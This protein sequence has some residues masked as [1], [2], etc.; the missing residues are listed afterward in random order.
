[1]RSGSPGPALSELLGE[2]SR[3]FRRSPRLLAGAMVKTPPVGSSA[4]APGDSR[5]APEPPAGPPPLPKDRPID[6]VYVVGAHRS[7]GTVLGTI[8]S[9]APGV[10]YGGELYRFPKPIFTPGDPRRLCSCGAP[11]AQCPFWAGVRA[12]T[13]RRPELLPK[14]R[15]GQLRTEAWGRLP[16]TLLRMLFDDRSV[17]RHAARME[18]FARV[19]ADRAGASVVVDSSYSALR[20]IL[21]RRAG[22]GGGRVRFIHL[23]RDGRNFLGSELGPASGTNPAPPWQRTPPAITARWTALHVAAIALCWGRR[24]TYLRVRYEDLMLRPAESLREIQR[25]LGIDLSETIHRVE[26]RQPIPMFHICAANR[27]RE[28]G[29]LTVRPELS[30]PP[31]LSKAQT[32]VYWTVAGILAL[33]FGYRVRATR[34]HPPAAAPAV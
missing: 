25:F 12:E 30:D 24:G 20:G 2:L 34:A 13:D 11:V 10:F 23:V 6:I 27:L 18:E 21:Y 7:G 31:K 19:L 5:K 17:D 33:A 14:L 4:M 22:L 8:L 15:E 28:A 3:S 26:S 9:G 1:M 16:L 32:A 29:S